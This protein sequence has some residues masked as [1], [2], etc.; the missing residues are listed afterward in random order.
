MKNTYRINSID[1]RIDG[2]KEIFIPLERTLKKLNIE[3]YLIGAL[4]RDIITI[5]HKQDPFTA[6]R[7]ID[8]AVM[9]L[10][11]EEYEVLKKSLIEDENFVQD[12]K[13][14]Y[15]LHCNGKI[16]DLLPF[17]KIESKE[18]TVKLHGK[19]ITTLSV[20]GLNEVFG[21]ANNV[22]IDDELQFFVS[23]FPGLCIL[24]L[25]AYSERPDIRSKD[26][27]D[28]N[29]I[30]EKYADMNVEYICKNHADIMDNDWNE[31]LS[32]RVL[33]RD[34]GIILKNENELKNKILDILDSSINDNEDSKIAQLMTSRK[35]TEENKL[36]VLKNLREGLVE[37]S[38]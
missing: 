27:L 3:F 11:N 19:D 32:A 37:F 13:E 34:M 4:A 33:G 12:E 2:I 22:M 24:K 1:L 36:E 7:D 30:I 15:R 14:L 9:V 16:I 10:S 5:V 25:I 31:N 17:G 38:L 6:T 8:I 29:F 35:D 23:S 28:I 26:I 20:L 18:R 21:F